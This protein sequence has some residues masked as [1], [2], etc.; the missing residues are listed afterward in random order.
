MFSPT[1]VLG[2]SSDLF[3]QLPIKSKKQMAE[4]P[5]YFS[6]ANYWCPQ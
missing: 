5:E 4:V 2:H 3:L 6:T 1:Q